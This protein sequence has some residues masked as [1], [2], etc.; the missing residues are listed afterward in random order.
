MRP[1]LPK[2]W[3]VE[4]EDEHMGPFCKGKWELDGI[5]PR[6][7]LYRYEPGGIFTKHRDGPIYKTA[8]QRS[9]FTVLVYLNVEYEG[10]NT[11]I[12]S[13][14]LTESFKVIPEVGSVFVMLQRTLH[15]GSKVES[16]RKFLLRCDVMYSRVEGTLEEVVHGMEKLAQAK[17]WYQL[18]SILEL[19]GNSLG[20]VDFYRRAYKLDPDVEVSVA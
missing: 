15:E 19:S 5:D 9:F 10:G 18:A 7:Q 4:A 3:T 8:H 14:D 1:L 2:Y 20:S 13:E 11:T 6:I 17:K 12:F 16:G